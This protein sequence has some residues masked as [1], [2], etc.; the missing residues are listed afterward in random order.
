M[1]DGKPLVRC[2]SVVLQS[3]V[4]SPDSRRVACQAYLA[5]D[6]VAVLVDGIP[7]RAIP[8]PKDGRFRFTGCIVFSPDSK[9]VA[10]GYGLEGGYYVVLDEQLF[11]PFPGGPPAKGPHLVFSRDSE[12]LAFACRVPQER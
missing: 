1:V 9:H 6:R 8:L 2:N 5:D 11:G 7:N 12:H 4:F 10:Y 3:V